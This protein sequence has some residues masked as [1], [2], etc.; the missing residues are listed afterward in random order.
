[1]AGRYG[2]DELSRFLLFSALAL[3]V[4]EFII[5]TF[6]KEL[7]VVSRILNL[8]GLILIILNFIRMFSKNHSGQYRLNQK[9]LR[10]K[11]SFLRFFKD[12]GR[13]GSSRDKTHKIFTCPSCSQRVRVPK[14]RGRIAITCPK[15]KAQFIKK[16]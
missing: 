15:C 12:F 7:Y 3:L 1:M 16:T 9:Y 11:A 5:N 4:V 6:F 13:W 14:G 8:I 2:V 10:A